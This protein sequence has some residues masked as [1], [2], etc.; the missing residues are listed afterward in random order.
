M[1]RAIGVVLAVGAI[2]CYD[3]Y[4]VR[5]NSLPAARAAT[6][7][8]IPLVTLEG[9]PITVSESSEIDV[10]LSD[11]SHVGGLLGSSGLAGDRMTVA[12]ASPGQPEMIPIDSVQLVE[13]EALDP[14]TTAAVVVVSVVGAAAVV[15][16]VVLG[17]SDPMDLDLDFSGL[18]F[19]PARSSARW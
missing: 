11:G 8:G 18:K 15:G 12:V 17:L 13:V 9:E 16:L 5:P 14:E 10:T 3:H 7:G 1:Q 6:S 19:R 2:G 4:R